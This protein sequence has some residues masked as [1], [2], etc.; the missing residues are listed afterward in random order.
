MAQQTPKTK[1]FSSFSLPE[2]FKQLQITHLQP[3]DIKTKPLAPS[4]FFQL[5]LAKLRRLFDLRSYE[6]SKKLLIDAFC[7][8]ALETTQRLK[9]W[10]GAAL[11]GEVAV[12]NV[13][14]LIAENKEYLEAPLLCIIEAKKDDFEQGLAQCLVA[15]QACAQ[16]NQSFDLI[17]IWGIVTN[18]ETWRF[19]KL[20]VTG[21]VFESLPYSI[22]ELGVVLGILSHIFQHCEQALIQVTAA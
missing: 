12:G 2:A 21:E 18:G 4:D 1:N 17:N 6:E 9:I 14:Y 10:K 15:M 22:G 20:M 3:W 8:E 13:D 11:R 7:E 5:R 19:Y 16:N